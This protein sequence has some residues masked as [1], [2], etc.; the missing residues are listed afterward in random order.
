MR[1]LPLRTLGFKREDVS[2]DIAHA[3]WKVVPRLGKVRL[4]GVFLPKKRGG[5]QAAE[6]DGGPGRA[7]EA[8]GLAAGEA[9][10]RRAWLL[11]AHRC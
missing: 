7:R 8:E 10:L 2:C 11:F 9:V 4:S 6:H 5:G 1:G 3:A